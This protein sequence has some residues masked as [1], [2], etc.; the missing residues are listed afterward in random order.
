MI[1]IRRV[2]DGKLLALV[3]DETASRF[4]D[5]V[6]CETAAAPADAQA[7]RDLLDDSRASFA[8]VRLEKMAKRT[9]R[10]LAEAS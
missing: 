3:D 7:K 10:R 9:E 8:K 4:R 1:A 5:A 6:G 2:S